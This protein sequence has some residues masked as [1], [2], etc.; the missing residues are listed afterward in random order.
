MIHFS[1]RLSWVKKEMSKWLTSLW[2]AGCCMNMF[3]QLGMFW[4]HWSTVDISFPQS[5]DWIFL[6]QN[7]CHQT[8]EL[9]LSRLVCCRCRAFLNM[10]NSSGLTNQTFCW[11]LNLVLMKTCKGHQ[12]AAAEVL[13]QI[14][15]SVCSV[16]P[17]VALFSES[18]ELWFAERRLGPE[19][20]SLWAPPLNLRHDI[21]YVSLC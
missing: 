18:A 12:V 5:L 16:R 4:E 7:K 11:N 17:A 10:C 6:S 8:F 3:P 1:W 20:T 19:T 13:T 9:F 2:N 14:C 15:L 21:D